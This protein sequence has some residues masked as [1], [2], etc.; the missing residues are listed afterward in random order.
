MN[1]LRTLRSDFSEAHG[2]Q[3]GNRLPN[4]AE[5]GSIKKLSR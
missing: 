3:E 5:G 4:A 1:K 2:N